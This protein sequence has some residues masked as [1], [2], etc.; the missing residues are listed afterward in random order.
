MGDGG[1]SVSQVNAHKTTS[2]DV[3]MMTFATCQS[4]RKVCREVSGE[5]FTPKCKRV[6]CGRCSHSQKK[7]WVG[8]WVGGRGMS[9]KKKDMEIEP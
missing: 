3:A 4:R 8:G 1:S 5:V 6:F 2:S 9:L 7:K